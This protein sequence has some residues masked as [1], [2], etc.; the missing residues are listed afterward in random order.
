L[1]KEHLFVSHTTLYKYVWDRRC[2][3]N[4]IEVEKFHLF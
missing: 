1:K 2:C 4:E 3:I